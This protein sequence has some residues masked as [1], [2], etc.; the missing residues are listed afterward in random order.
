[1]LVLAGFDSSS[2][3]DINKIKSDRKKFIIYLAYTK[4]YYPQVEII[5]V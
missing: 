3:D 5:T 4:E 2:T 1:M